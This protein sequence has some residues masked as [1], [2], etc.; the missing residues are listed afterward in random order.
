MP[1]IPT[2]FFSALCIPEN[3]VYEGLFLF[4]AICFILNLLLILLAIND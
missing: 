4:K 1:P 3:T 2:A